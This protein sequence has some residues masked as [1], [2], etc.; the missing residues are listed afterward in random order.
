MKNRHKRT[1]RIITG[2]A[3]TAFLGAIAW[4]NESIDYLTKIGISNVNPGYAFLIT[5]FLAVLS[6]TWVI[7]ELMD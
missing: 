1:L 5:A 4:T 2:A 3:L 6:L 7:W